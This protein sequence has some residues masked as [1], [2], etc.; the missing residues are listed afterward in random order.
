MKWLLKGTFFQC[1]IKDVCYRCEVVR[2]D[3]HVCE[4]YTGQT[5]RPIKVRI[6]EHLRDARNFT[7]EKPVGS[8]LSHYVGNLFFNNIPHTLNWSILAQKRHFSP[9]QNFCMLC[10]VEKTLI[11]YNPE[12]TSLNFRNE[13]FGFCFHKDKYLLLNS[14]YVLHYLILFFPFF[15]TIFLFHFSNLSM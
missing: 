3:N 7:P 12:L 8:R 10:N 11:I 2:D 4:N 5:S 1:S 13:L 6:G 14:W 9:V 15:I